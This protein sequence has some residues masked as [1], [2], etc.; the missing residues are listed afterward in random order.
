MSHDLTTLVEEELEGPET[1][2]TFL[3]AARALGGEACEEFRLEAAPTD[4]ED[5]RYE[6]ILVVCPERMPEGEECRA[7]NVFRVRLVPVTAGSP[8]EG[9]S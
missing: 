5:D 8:S 1:H 4:T 6:R 2:V 9:P 3:A 7:E